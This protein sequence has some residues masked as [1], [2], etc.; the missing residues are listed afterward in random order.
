[1]SALPDAPTSLYRPHAEAPARLLLRES[2]EPGAPAQAFEVVSR[3]DFVPGHLHRPVGEARSPL[4]LVLDG[5]GT[6]AR[7]TDHGL[8]IA[9]IDLPLLGERRSPKLT[10]RLVGGHARLIRD[11]PLDA[12][13]RALVEEFARQAISDVVRTLEALGEHPGLDGNRVALVGTGIGASVCAWALPFAPGVRACVLAGP[14]GAFADAQLDP[15]SRIGNAELGD[16]RCR[17]YE[18]EDGPSE[19]AVQALARVLPGQPAPEELDASSHDGA[20]AAS[21][22]TSILDFVARSLDH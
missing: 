12:D 11:E 2:T 15:A 5:S 8:A 7:G 21:E 18:T 13:T 19:D 6:W 9:R 14:V 17:L 16:V 20:L 3:G 4:V 22:R 1:M 10:E